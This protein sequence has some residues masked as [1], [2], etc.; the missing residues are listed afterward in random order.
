MVCGW[1]RGGINI[2]AV[3][4]RAKGI[5]KIEVPVDGEL[6]Y[7]LGLVEISIKACSFEMYLSCLLN[8]SN[9]KPSKQDWKTLLF[10][11]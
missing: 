2:N 1:E 11:R 5:I 3:Y 4:H 8:R 10:L 7:I 6:L 9:E